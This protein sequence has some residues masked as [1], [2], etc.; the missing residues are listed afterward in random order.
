[1]VVSGGEFYNFE[2][3]N[4]HFGREAMRFLA[5]ISIDVDKAEVGVFVA[6]G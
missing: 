6:L 5:I 4:N 2:L 1:M 3:Q